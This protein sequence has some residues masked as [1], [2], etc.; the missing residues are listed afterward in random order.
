MI[1]FRWLQTTIKYFL[2]RFGAKSFVV[3]DRLIKTINKID[4]SIKNIIVKT[5]DCTISNKNMILPIDYSDL[6]KR[7]YYNKYT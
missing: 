7:I 1:Q 2:T 3:S 6:A 5:G 4:D